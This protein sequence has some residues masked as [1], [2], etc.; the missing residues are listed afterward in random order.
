MS[1]SNL[2]TSFLSPSITYAGRQPFYGAGSNTQTISTFQQ[3]FTSSITGNSAGFG[4][5]VGVNIATSSLSGNTGLIDI[6]SSFTATISSLSAN[7]ATIDTISSTNINTSTIAVL[8]DL[9]L[10][11]NNLTTSGTFPFELLLNGIPIATT[12]NISS[13]SDWAYF[14]AVSSINAGGNYL[15]NVPAIEMS[16]ANGFITGVSSI[17]GSVYPPVAGGVTSFNTLTGAVTISAGANITLSPVGND[18]AINATVPSGTTPSTITG[19]NTFMLSDATLASEFADATITAGGGFGG[20]ITM[21]ANSGDG[22]I[23]GGAIT[24]TANGGGGPA[25]LF[26]AITM[27]ANSGSAAG[28]ATGGSIELVANSGTSASNLTSKISLN[29]GGLNL[30]SGVGSPFASLFGYTYMNASLGIS[31][32]AG[33]FTSGLQA[34]GTV[35]LYGTTGITLGSDT[36]ANRF[37]PTWDTVN[38]PANL[39]INGRSTVLGDAYVDINNVNDISFDGAGTGTISGV[40]TINGVAYPP[41]TPPTVIQA[42]GTTALTPANAN[43]TYVLTSGLSQDFTTAGLGAGDAGLVWYVKNAFAT[44]ITIEENGTGIAGVTGTVFATTVIANSAT[45]ILFWDGT[46]LT[47]Y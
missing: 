1:V 27:T 40:Q 13:L 5:V 44:D 22:T 28:I 39:S 32:V 6:L 47:M 42:A 38:P 8:G 29:A 26:G 43:T 25:G 24:M 34:P 7:S 16:G 20:N 46:I 23:N 12:S 2:G 3:L 21:T 30:Y 36:Y 37:F 10:N 11:G 41:P 14:P 45:Q 33:A 4:S 15:S 9:D 35:Y 18:V 31:L 19:V 17:N